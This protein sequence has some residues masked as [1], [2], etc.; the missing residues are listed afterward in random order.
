M[1]IEEH[2]IMAMWAALGAGALA[3]IAE[4]LHAR[5]VRWLGRLAFGADERPRSW[6]VAAPAIRV[7]AIAA[8]IASLVVL[9]AFEGS[10]RAQERKAAALRHVMVLLDV[11]PSMQLEDGGET[12]QQKRA[13]RA[14][15][16][17]RSVMNRVPGDG[18][19]FSMACFYSHALPLV[20]SCSDRELIWHFADDLPLYMAYRQGKTDLVK[21]LNQAGEMAADFERKST[22][23]LVLTDGDTVPDSGLKSLPSSVAD[24]ILV[25]VGDPV[26]GTFIDGHLSRQDSASLSQLARRLGGKYHNG[27]VKHIP[28]EWLSRLTAPDPHAAK[29]RINLR[30]AAI[31]VFA[32][33][34]VLLCL[35][36]LALE[37]FGS[38]W[39][40]E[41]FMAPR[42]SL[43]RREHENAE[44]IS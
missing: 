9:I 29:F 16:I 33:S 35:R 36:P 4:M 25:G 3:M 15:D 13:A 1:K 8:A 31:I 5:R 7:L 34:T 11:S 24:V 21:S 41:Q 37:A 19:K 43:Q 6:T 20:K 28:S 17:L 38:E 2:L 12:G 39:K 40:P 23:L 30:I 22:T 10:S 26:R 27:N 18:V 14:A 44:A 42:L 32:A